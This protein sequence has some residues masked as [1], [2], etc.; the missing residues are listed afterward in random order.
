MRRGGLKGMPASP[1]RPFASAHVP[2]AGSMAADKIIAAEGHANPAPGI[3][4]G[5]PAGGSL[6]NL[7]QPTQFGS[8]AHSPTQKKPDGTNWIAGAVKHKG[9]LHRQLGVPEGKKIPATKLAAAAKKGG[10]LGAR[11]RLAQ[12]L[13]KLK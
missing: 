9:A 8:P 12:T 10:K 6:A 1:T 13:K 11:A 3:G 2:G 7:G 5:S 4:L